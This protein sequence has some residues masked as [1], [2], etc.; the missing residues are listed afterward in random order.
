MICLPVI[1]STFTLPYGAGVPDCVATRPLSSAARPAT[2]PASAAG[3]VLTRSEID[4]WIF[5]CRAGTPWKLKQQ[6]IERLAQVGEPVIPTL[7][8]CMRYHYPAGVKQRF[9]DEAETAK[10]EGRLPVG[11]IALSDASIYDIPYC[12]A[13]ALAKIGE[14]AIP[15]LVEFLKGDLRRPASAVNPD[16]VRSLCRVGTPAVPALVNLVKETGDLPGTPVVAELLGQIGDARAIPVL[17]LVLR[18]TDRSYALRASAAR[19]LKALKARQ[20]VP[21]LIDVF[22][23]KHDFHQ[24]AESFIDDVVDALATLT[25]RSFGLE[26]VPEQSRIKAEPIPAHYALRGT[27]E[28]RRRVEQNWQDWFVTHRS[29]YG[30][31]PQ[32]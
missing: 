11:A 1:V 24:E 32:Q 13:L 5:D 23:V 10:K 30:A 27:F 28:Q 19:A 31:L 8:D 20:A 15:S 29:E 2:V 25:G 14:P 26:L 9:A 18:D 4:Q 12:A 16:A 6:R 22:H 17:I 7:I 3:R 21:D